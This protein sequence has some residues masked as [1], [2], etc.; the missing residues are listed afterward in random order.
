MAEVP[1]HVKDLIYGK[2]IGDLEPSWTVVLFKSGI[3]LI[4]GGVLSMVFCGQFGLGLSPLAVTFNHHIHHSV[5]PVACAVICGLLF[6]FVPILVLRSLCTA[7]QFRVLLRRHLMPMVWFI[8]FAVIF[9]SHGEIGA[10]VL[11][12]LIWLFAAVGS[13]KVYG[14]LLDLVNKTRLSLSGEF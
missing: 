12:L 6:S 3:A 5:G 13:F 7:I 14:Y 11:Y 4:P 2:V 8:A 9:A 10:D 1:K